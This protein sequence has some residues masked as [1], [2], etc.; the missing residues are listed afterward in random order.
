MKP[1]TSSTISKPNGRGSAKSSPQQGEA[2][3]HGD[4]VYKNEK[5][6]LLSKRNSYT[7]CNLEHP[8]F[9]ITGHQNQSH[10]K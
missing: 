2:Y 7:T 8:H 4:V 3:L 9:L 6:E 1:K 10:P 5:G